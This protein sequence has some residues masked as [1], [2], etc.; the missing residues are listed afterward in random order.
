[1]GAKERSLERRFLLRSESLK[2]KP[3]AHK[4]HAEELMRKM[5]TV[6]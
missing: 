2:S 6:V 1:M 5:P 4:Y 3:R